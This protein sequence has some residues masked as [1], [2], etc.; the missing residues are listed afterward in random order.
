M[1]RRTTPPI[2][3]RAPRPLRADAERNRQRIIAAA[4]EVFAERGLNVTLDDIGHHAGVGVGTVYRRFA[5]RDELIE[6]VFEDQVGRMIAAA[7]Q[8]LA[9]EDPWEGLVEF[10]LVSAEDFAQ[11]RGLREVLLERAHG[12]TAVAAMRDRFTPVADALIARAQEA[13]RLRD[14][15]ETTDFPVIQIMLGSVSRHSGALAPE[16]WRRYL[17]LIL[18]GMRRDRPGPSPLPVRALEPHEFDQTL[19]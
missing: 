10:F 2:E 8:A 17:T 6:A 5:H 12:K 19:M 15:I 3:S 1:S 14:D 9:H 16:L 18:D 7:E 4:H 11:N 13:G